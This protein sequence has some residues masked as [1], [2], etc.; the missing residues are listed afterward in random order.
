MDQLDALVKIAQ[1]LTEAPNATQR[2]RRLLDG[3]AG[4]IPFEAAALLR[5]DRDALVPVASLGLMPSALGRRYLLREHPRLEIICK[6][7]QPVLFP[8][9]TALPDPFDGLLAGD[10]GASH[11]IHACLGCPLLIH[12]ELIGALTA[13]A[14]TPA[15][16]AEVDT[17]FLTAVA[18]LAAAEMRTASLIEA[19]EQVAERQ[20]LI[21]RD[22][23]RDTIAM[24]SSEIIGVS[25]LICRLRR[26]IDLVARSDLTVLITGETGVGKELVARALYAA[27]ERRSQQLIYVSCAAL[28]ETLVESELF[29]HVRGSFTGASADRPGKFEVADG[30]TLFLDEIGELPL[31]V[32][33]K[34]LRALQE[35]EIQRVGADRPLSV[36]VRVLAATNRNL[37]EQVKAGRF[38]ADL[39]HRLNVFPLLVPPLR[40]RREDIPLLAGHFCDLA[41]RRLGLG[42]VRLAADAAGALCDYA[43]PGNVRELEN[44]ISRVVLRASATVARGEPVILTARHLGPE[45]S[46]VPADG[47]AHY[48]E[49]QPGTPQIKPM[50]QAM[51]DFRQAHIQR[52]LEASGHCWAAA[53]RLLGMDRGNLHHL[54]TRLG[55][56]PAAKK[57]GSRSR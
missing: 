5:L 2:K 15:A 32:Q 49:A 4:V 41:R 20:G 22:L 40:D 31:G 28:P 43:W 6:S 45:L 12:G 7:Q 57:R 46:C 33:P 30:G 48:D 35:G 8:A 38:R 29:G 13:D 14:R 37:E 9:D 1:D 17:R 26:E 50:Q 19:L 23:M 56:A 11:R 47:A 44:V 54:A 51:R 55:L 18:A 36:S 25:P 10:P 39:F 34:L 42:P 27:S 53:A 21:A 3:L 16:F 52:A 24:Q